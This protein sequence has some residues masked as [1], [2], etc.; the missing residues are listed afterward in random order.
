MMNTYTNGTCA[1]QF[2]SSYVLMDAE[3][4][5]YI[6]AGA[7]STR[8]AGLIIDGVIFAASVISGAV[9]LKSTLQAINAVGKAVASTTKKKLVAQLKSCLGSA[10]KAIFG[11]TVSTSLG[12]ANLICDIAL[13]GSFGYAVACGLD[14]LDGNYNGTI[15]FL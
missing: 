6:D 3:E 2:P 7:M 4:M 15:S 9:A 5:E 10:M 11:Y 13:G 14:Y 8:T 1:L 12:A